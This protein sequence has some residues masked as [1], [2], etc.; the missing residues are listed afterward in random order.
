MQCMVETNRS[1]LHNKVHHTMTGHLA[2]L[3]CLELKV[4]QG[5]EP[6]VFF[7]LSQ[8]KSFALNTRGVHNGRNSGNLESPH[9][10]LAIIDLGFPKSFAELTAKSIDL[11]HED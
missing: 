2:R 9:K 5:F 7:N 10:V 6:H 4:R 8:L 1:S 11:T 3:I